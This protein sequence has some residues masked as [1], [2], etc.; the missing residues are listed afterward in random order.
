MATATL[1][2]I[3]TTGSAT[4]ATTVDIPIGSLVCVIVN[5]VTA[6]STPGSVSDAHG[7]VYTFA[8]QS[9]DAVQMALF[10][11]NQ[12]TFDIPIGSAFSAAGN[13][14][15]DIFNVLGVVFVSPGYNGGLDKTAQTFN[16]T[17]GTTFSVGIGPFSQATEF[18]I[19]AWQDLQVAFA[20]TDSANVGWIQLS[21]NTSSFLGIYYQFVTAN[22]ALTFTPS[23][24]PSVASDAV[25]G[26]FQVTT[27]P[28]SIAGL[29][30]V[31]W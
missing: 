12:T 2:A 10:Y 14:S 15:A 20:T 9:G 25:L 6:G 17:P 22:T 28:L 7:N 18:V 5:V 8:V 29:V 3:N 21:S 19:A 31:E 30:D 16:T 27:P 26:S 4:I 23:F 1:A 13:P 11:C 24:T